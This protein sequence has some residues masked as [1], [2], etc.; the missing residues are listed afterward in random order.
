M[1][2]DRGRV[3]RAPPPASGPSARRPAAAVT[4]D[5]SRRPRRTAAGPRCGR[6]L[7]GPADG[8]V[9]LTVSDSGLGI[10]PADQERIFE[11]F[12]Q[13]DADQPDRPVGTGLGLP[14]VRRVTAQLGG[15]LELDSAPGRGSAFRVTLP[16]RT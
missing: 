8:E 6:S 10:A 11:E 3:R 1:L 5:E 12:A 13:V 4:Q 7:A 16:A 15:R 9:T 14:F 2:C